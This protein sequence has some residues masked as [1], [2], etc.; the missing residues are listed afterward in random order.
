VV[1]AS[2]WGVCDEAFED[3]HEF[4]DMQSQYWE[5]QEE[6]GQM[7]TLRTRLER[8]EKERSEMQAKW[9]R[10]RKALIAEI[11]R[12]RALLSY[13]SIPMEE[14]QYL[15]DLDATAAD[16]EALQTAAAEQWNQEDWSSACFG[17]AAFEMPPGIEASIDDKL[18]RLGGLLSNTGMQEEDLE[19]GRGSGATSIASTLQAMFPHAT[20]R[21]EQEADGN[22]DDRSQEEAEP[23]E[24]S[25]A[26]HEGS[27]ADPQVRKLLDDLQKSTGSHLDDRARISFQALSPSRASEALHKVADLI[28]A[29]GGNC[30]NLSSI[31]QSVCRKLERSRSAAETKAAAAASGSKD[32]A[33]KAGHAT[34]GAGECQDPWTAARMAKAAERGISVWQEGQKWRLKIELVGSD[35]TM[36][37]S[38]MEMF[39]KHLRGQLKEFKAAHGVRALRQCCGEVDFSG[40]GLSNQAL[41]MLLECLSHFEVHVASLKLY[42]NRISRAGI[43]A[44]CEFLRKNKSAGQ[45]YEMHLSHNEVD[46]ESCM[47][48]LQ[49]LKAQKQRYPPKRPVEGMEGTQLV[50]VWLR[51][52]QNK[53][54]DAAAL[55]KT[56]T[57]EGISSCSARSANG[58]GPGKCTRPECPLLHLY[59]FTDQGC[60]NSQKGN[61]SIKDWPELGASGAA[62]E[63][64]KKKGSRRAGM[65]EKEKA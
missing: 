22:E 50:P 61:E 65:A 54:V 15:L 23:Q 52:N 18:Q 39:I 24:A 56:L 27:M 11:G 25:P 21:T 42:K 48:L 12:Y 49:T 55:L 26:Q 62:E 5:D 41:W 46:D 1:N 33:A 59:L 16:A 37:D 35:A 2:N 64:K 8:L 63:K 9:E 57:A 13:Y 20:V 17:G 34:S 31:L 3:G 29:Q 60:G 53:I 43:L 19:N 32:V 4:Q 28:K 40:N 44:L 14:V 36:P 58:C 47:E 38:A 7:D 51:L 45:V 6:A 30:R 10:D